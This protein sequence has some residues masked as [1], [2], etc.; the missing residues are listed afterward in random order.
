ML[1]L[2]SDFYDPSAVRPA[3]GAGHAV[4]LTQNKNTGVSAQPSRGRCQFAILR[5]SGHQIITSVCL[6][7][8]VT[9]VRTS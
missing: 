9:V 4:T 6:L 1:V 3:T 7:Y 8:S 2:S 5:E